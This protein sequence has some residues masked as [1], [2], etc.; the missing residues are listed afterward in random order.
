MTAA[1]AERFADQRQSRPADPLEEIRAQL[2]ATNTWRPWANIIV[3]VD[4]P[5][6]IENRARRRFFQQIQKIRDGLSRHDFQNL[7]AIFYGSSR[8]AATIQSSDKS[9]HSKARRKI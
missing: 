6:R 1:I 8:C 2:L 4:V 7:F 5:P 9:P 3:E